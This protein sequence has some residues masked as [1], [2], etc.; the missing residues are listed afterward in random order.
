VEESGEITLWG[1]SQS[2][3]AQRNLIAQSMGISQS[4]MR[5][6]APLVGGGFGSKA[7]VS[8]EALVVAIATKATAAVKLLLT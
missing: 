6:I 2:P 1:S 5:V 8:M 7:G 3:F 4:R